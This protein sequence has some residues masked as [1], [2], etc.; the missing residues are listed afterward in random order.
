VSLFVG[1]VK[2]RSVQEQAALRS[3]FAALQA[4]SMAKPENA[5]D[6]QAQTNYEPVPNPRVWRQSSVRHNIRRQEFGLE[7]FAGLQE[8]T[9]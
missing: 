6:G 5:Q 4:G 3:S 1:S 8:F 7:L 9:A 2:A